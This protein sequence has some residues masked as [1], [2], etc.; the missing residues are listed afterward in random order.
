MLL[1]P[2]R[3]PCGPVL[4]IHVSIIRCHQLASPSSLLLALLLVVLPRVLLL[5]LPEAGAWCCILAPVP[6]LV[7]RLTGTLFVRW[8]VLGNRPVLLWRGGSTPSLHVLF[9]ARCG[10]L[11]SRR[12]RSAC[13]AGYQGQA[14]SGARRVRVCGTSRE[15]CSYHPQAPR[16]V[17]HHRRTVAARG[18]ALRTRLRAHSPVSF[19]AP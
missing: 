4:V 1:R 3:A 16:E 17:P 6:S 15:G 18:P 10:V 19:G 7:G 13:P 8:W 14:S 11:P 2:P 12:L 5:V 9:T